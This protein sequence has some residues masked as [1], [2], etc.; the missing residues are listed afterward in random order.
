MMNPSALMIAHRGR[1]FRIKLFACGIVDYSNY[2]SVRHSHPVYHLILVSRGQHYFDC[3][4][5][6]TELVGTNT[7]LLINPDEEHQFRQIAG[8]RFEHIGF[9]WRL[10]DEEG[11][12]ARFPLQ[13][14]LGIPAE[15]CPG[16]AICRISPLEAQKCR[17]QY[18]KLLVRMDENSWQFQFFS[19]VYSLLEHF[20]NS[21]EL[22]RD[23][24]WESVA[25]ILEKNVGNAAFS[26][27]ALGK[28]LGKKPDYLSTGYRAEPGEPSAVFCCR[29]EWIRRSCFSMKQTNRFQQL[30]GN[31]ALPI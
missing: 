17:D 26:P 8:E 31:V 18:R 6:G 3:E 22:E 27:A 19:M 21:P 15:K 25:Q 7:L 4:S 2:P 20:R 16:A 1:C 11:R 12:E 14:L 29:R 5:R 13:E 23:R 9:L 24:L 28:A 10:I 30:L